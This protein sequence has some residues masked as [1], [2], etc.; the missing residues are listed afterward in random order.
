VNLHHVAESAVGTGLAMVAY[1][2]IRRAAAALTWAAIRRR[3]H[4]GK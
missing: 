4:G 1:Q 2:V 3:S